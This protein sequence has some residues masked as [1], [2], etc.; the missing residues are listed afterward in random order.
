MTLTC[1]RCHTH[2]YDPITQTEY[3]QLLAFF[4]STAE[5]AMDGNSYTYN[6][7]IK[8]PKDQK[9]WQHWREVEA[10]KIR[11]IQ[12]ANVLI[13]DQVKLSEQQIQRWEVADTEGRLA[14]L[15]DVNGPFAIEDAHAETVALLAREQE[16]AKGYT[17]TLVAKELDNPR[18]TKVLHRGEYLSLIHI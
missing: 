8:A 4:N 16:A 10:E 15:A 14:Q 7:V 11:L 5:S 6:P 13:G 18:E 1:S 17:T 12:V 3:Y 2:K 9:G